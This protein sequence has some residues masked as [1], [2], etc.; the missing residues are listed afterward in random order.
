MSIDG[1]Y[2]TGEG[3]FFGGSNSYFKSIQLGQVVV[4]SK[5][6]DNKIVQIPVTQTDP[7]QKFRDEA[8]NIDPYIV[9][10]R[11]SGNNFDTPIGND[12]EL[13]NCYPLIPKFG[14]P[15][16]KKNEMVLLFMTSPED[17]YSD[18][19]YI[20]PITSDI[21]QINKQTLLAGATTNLTSGYYNNLTNPTKNEE[22]K[23][24]YSEYDNENTFV[25]NGR[26]NA[27]IV[28]KDSEVLIRA[29]KF[30]ENDSKKFN[31]INPAYIQVKNGFTFTDN[32]NNVAVALSGIGSPSKPNKISVNNIVADKINLLT[33]NGS[34][35]FDLTNRDLINNKTPYITDDELNTILTTAHPM[36]FGDVLLEYLIA[37][38]QA[39]QSHI[40]NAYGAA[41]PT[42]N[43]NVGSSV[44]AFGIKA[45]ELENKMLSK[46]IRI[47]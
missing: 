22:T 4:A 7:N 26:N 31:K 15:I 25:I 6:V 17:R 14:A 35:T 39:F 40:H 28:F 12:N 5:D 16:P 18:R 3:S 29:G 21:T 23:G 37:L 13:P 20:G 30:V 42:D 8:F 38:R 27:D 41:P 46:N 45:A 47:N 24:I 34:P 2:V 36:V 10:C 33:Y 1:K 32:T 44:S 19:Y 11:I 43:I 9:K